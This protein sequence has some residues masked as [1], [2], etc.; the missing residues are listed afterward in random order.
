MENGL[1]V[2][3]IG[4]D[5]LVYFSPSP[6]FIIWD[7]TTDTVSSMRSIEMTPSLIKCSNKITL[8]LLIHFSIRLDSA[9]FFLVINQ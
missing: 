9:C 1:Y 3:I 2:S 4:L 6:I 7:K 8:F 5:L